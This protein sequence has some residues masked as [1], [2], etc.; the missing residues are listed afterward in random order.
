MIL[1][2]EARVTGDRFSTFAITESGEHPDEIQDARVV[3]AFTQSGKT[4]WLLRRPGGGWVRLVTRGG[5]TSG[6]YEMASLDLTT[7]FI[8]RAAELG[9]TIIWGA[10]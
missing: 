6:A 8:A 9:A 5:K 10:S 3:G 2:I 1:A 4:H 7:E